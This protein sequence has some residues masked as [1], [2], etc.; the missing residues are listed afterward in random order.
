MRAR[1]DTEYAARCLVSFMRGGDA[2]EVEIGSI[3]V[4]E[5]LRTIR[6]FDASTFQRTW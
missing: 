4:A 5:A 1:L 6:D 2:E 3:L